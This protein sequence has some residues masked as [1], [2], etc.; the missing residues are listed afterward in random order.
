MIAQAELQLSPDNLLS[1]QQ[2]LI[3]GG[4]SLRGYQQNSRAGDNGFRFSIE[5][6]TTLHKDEF[7]NP[8][9]QVAPFADIGAVWNSSDNSNDVS[10]ENFLAS[11]GLGFIWQPIPNLQTRIDY[12]VPLVESSTRGENAQDRGLTFS[13]GY[14]F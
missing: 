4:Q 10:G 9:L 7:G 1:S 2:F 13:A 3:G 8:N 6:R 5:N 11:V 12:A 14:S